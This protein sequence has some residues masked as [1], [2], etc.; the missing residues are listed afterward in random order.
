[1]TTLVPMR[2]GTVT[3]QTDGGAVVTVPVAVVA[4]A[5]GPPSPAR[6][7][8]VRQAVGPGQEWLA[9]VP[10]E[11]VQ[12]TCLPMRSV[13]RSEPTI[14]RYAAV[15]DDA[16]PECAA[17]RRPRVVDARDDPIVMSPDLNS[18]ALAEWAAVLV[19][20]GAVLFARSARRDSRESAQAAKSSAASSDRSA[21][22]AE[23]SADVALL[24][25]RRAIERADV[26]W[27]LIGDLN[28]EPDTEPGYISVRND[29]T[30]EARAVVAK[31]LLDHIDDAPI[32][33]TCD[34]IR[35][36]ESFVF[37][38]RASYRDAVAKARAPTDP[39]CPAP[40]SV[41][42]PVQGSNRLGEPARDSKRLRTHQRH[43]LYLEAP[44]RRSL[45]EPSVSPSGPTM[46]GCLPHA[47]TSP[48]RALRTRSVGQINGRAWL[49]LG[50]G[51][52][53]VIVPRED[54]PELVRAA[55]PRGPHP[56][57]DRPDGRGESGD[58]PS[59]SLNARTRH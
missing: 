5:P 50:F 22:A 46:P 51:G 30:T 9:W 35:P 3:A 12:A 25:A 41:A 39:P 11:R 56:T 42:Y 17:S 15:L 24:E 36:T 29:G 59:R 21:V 7:L 10:A 14:D 34:A 23:K 8:C 53:A 58:D 20:I 37:D 2:F 45:S 19:A 33:V 57:A 55:P 27:T 18:S 52:A 32:A 31:M 13:E 38:A 48:V 26:C 1:M 28:R 6:W 54:R 49:A 47:L 16:W 40:G 4:K 43:V 44:C